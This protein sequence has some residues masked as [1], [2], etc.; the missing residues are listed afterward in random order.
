MKKEEYSGQN[1]AAGEHLPAAAVCLIGV[2]SFSDVF[3]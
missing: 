3:Y 2:S 1:S